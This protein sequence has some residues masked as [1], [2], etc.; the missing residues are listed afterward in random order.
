MAGRTL[1]VYL[2]ADTS[3]F[4]AGM[5]SAQSSMTGFDGKI[6]NVADKLS[7]ALSTAMLGATVAA[8]AMAVKLGVDGV[9]AAMDDDA[10]AAKLAQ[11]LTNLGLAHDIAPVEAMIDALQRQTG[12]ADDQLRPAYGRLVTSLGDTGRATEALKLALDISAGSGKSLDTVVAALSKAYDGNTGALGRLGTG[13]DAQIL[14]TG[15]M[16]AITQALATTFSGQAQTAAGTY[17][18]SINRLTVGFG[19]LQESFGAGFLDAIGQA[20]TATGD[21]MTTMEELQPLMEAIGG[22]VGDQVSTYSELIGLIND[23]K[24][25]FDD[26]GATLGPFKTVMDA[27]VGATQG[28][29][30]PLR[31]VIELANGA[32]TALK[33]LG[34]IQG[35][36]TFQSGKITS[37]GGGVFE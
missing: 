34:V 36:T 3:K 37:T 31:G 9:K 14:K 6:T 26:L 23:A 16:D 10:A 1:T 4:R 28:L 33:N 20:D 13:L 2:A 19:E 30:S 11:T 15:D 7:G 35:Q 21:F 18:G 25:A 12:V 5:T 17:Q 24:G 32:I 22:L 29:L 27:A 8:G